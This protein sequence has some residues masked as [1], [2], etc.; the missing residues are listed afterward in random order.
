MEAK[1]QAM[2]E[3][4]SAEKQGAAAMADEALITLL[5]KHGKD[6]HSISISPRATV[7]DLKE[8]LQQLTNVL[9][10]GQKLIFKGKVLD[11]NML[12]R[13]AAL[14]NNSKLMMIGTPGVHQGISSP[15][16]QNVIASSGSTLN[17]TI[18]IGFSDGS[19]SGF[20]VSDGRSLFNDA[21]KTT[22]IISL[23]DRKQE[24]VPNRVW[25]I[26]PAARV[27]DLAGNCLKRFPADVCQLV[28]LQKLRL[29][30]NGFRDEQLD[31]QGIV[32]LKQLTTLALDHNLLTRVPA[33]VSQLCELK[34]LSAAYNKMVQIAE[35][36]GT[37][38][39]L[40]KFNLSHNCLKELPSSIGQCR[41]LVEADF[42]ANFLRDV[43]SS[44]GHITKLKALNLNYN[45]L[46]TF[47]SEVLTGC[48]E[49]TTLGLHGN[50]LTIE[51]LRE[52][53][54][55]AEFDNRRKAKH[56]KQLEFSV[57]ESS[58]GFDEGADSQQWH[59]F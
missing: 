47:P 50:E 14:S 33:E 42:S 59:H 54:G 35:E 39:K 10:R 19:R 3:E 32:M 2:A 9:P 23:R 8:M 4:G 46:K 34:V 48:A 13:D 20:K 6:T 5:C 45:A 57:L 12:L 44:L 22:G 15:A 36:V 18:R 16:K 27:L 56:S 37:L 26:G 1:R 43:P 58:G 53:E 11:A 17:K 30:D 40:E 49:L 38:V 41:L 21:W 7:N 28:N 25:A 51:Y 52:L 31:W 24:V 29:S 55:W